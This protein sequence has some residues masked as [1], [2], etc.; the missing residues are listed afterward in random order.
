[1]IY[2]SRGKVIFLK[3]FLSIIL[4]LAMLTAMFCITAGAEG[5]AELTPTEISELK[6]RRA[7]ANVDGFY[8]VADVQVLLKAAAGT[9]E[10][11]EEYDVNMDGTTSVEDAL[12]VLRE[13]AGIK[14]VLTSD[15]TLALFNAKVNGVK[16]RETGFPG[17]EKTVTATCNSMKLTQE[18]S[19]SNPVVA[20]LIVN[21][22]SCKDL[23]YDKYV[24]KMVS[25]M[26]SSGNLTQADKDNIA[27][28][29]K[30]AV[31]YK[32]PQQ[33][34]Q[35]AE[36]GDYRAHFL[37]FPRD[38][39]NT[40]S[41]ITT[42]DIATI[43]YSMSSGNIIYTLR[44]PNKKYTSLAAY[45]AN[46]YAKVMN[47]VEIDDSST[48]KNIELKNGTVVVTTDAATGAMKTANYSYSYYS[49]IA[50]PPQVQTDDSLGT[51]TVNLTTKTNATVSES[52]VF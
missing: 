9:S 28:M 23:E 34:T 36:K 40:A 50:A 26:E 18:V 7:D 15:E 21:R 31:E 42:A 6:L 20:A 13:V 33:E 14:P 39:K 49:E 11:K 19:A 8:S 22:M 37:H 44:L 5:E 17:F 43:A 2:I 16:N 30:S 27:A 29:E 10:D 25:M 41:E 51:I 46:P 48:V 3:K 47:V 52:I 32:N 12:A 38:R 35:K 45:E 4:A 1:M 24:E